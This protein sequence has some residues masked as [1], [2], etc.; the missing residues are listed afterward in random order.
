MVLVTGGTGMVGMHLIASL[1]KR[2]EQVRALHRAGSDFQPVKQFF[3]Y[4]GLQLE[5]VEW[6]VCELNDIPAL[7]D[8][9]EGCKEVFHAAALVSF[10][11]K[12]RKLIYETNVQG[13]ENIVNVALESD[14]EVLTYISSVAALGRDERTLVITEDTEWKDD[15]NLSNYARSKHMAEREVW[16][17][18]EEGLKVVVVNP[19]I[20]LGIGDFCRSSA[21]IFR[22][23]D[24]G[25]PFYPP[26][27]NGF[28]A[29][30]DV[31]EA[32]HFL[33]ENDL[34]NDRFLLVTEHMK[35]DELFAKVG[36]TID[37]KV[38]KKEAPF[39]LMR[40]VQILGSIKEFLT[41][42]RAF[43]TREGIRNASNSYHYDNRKI[44][45]SGFKFTGLDSVIEETGKYYRSLVRS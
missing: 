37:A 38:P 24:K 19:G 28:V 36:A 22:Q 23:L 26:G 17:G 29:V 39:W 25:M 43:V 30:Q 33:K 31:V 11:N 13:T 12:D 27:S 32:C 42:K 35:F 20:I 3:E 45:E 21:E 14:I 44:K 16:R 6:R 34:H 5:Q 4:S 8:A 15:P 10:H 40:T 7:E 2:G 1:L 41:G 9:M 18:M